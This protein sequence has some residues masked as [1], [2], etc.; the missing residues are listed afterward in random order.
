[1]CRKTKAWLIAAAALVLSGLLI[2][3]GVMMALDWDFSKLSTAE[4]ETNEYTITESFQNISLRSQTCNVVLIPSEEARVVCYEQS[5]MKHSVSVEGDT[6]V[7]AMDD[8]RKWYDHLGIHMEYP[9]ITVY[10]PQKQYGSITAAAT[11]G[12]I[13]LSGLSAGVLDLSVTTGDITAKDIHCAGDLRL[14]TTTGD[15]GLSTVSCKNLTAKGRTGDIGLEDV[16]TVEK[17]D[18]QLTTGDV[19]M[20]RCDATELKIKTTTG[21]ITG[22]LRSPKIITAKTATGSIR[23]PDSQTG[24]MCKLS[25]TT[26]D[27]TITLE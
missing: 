25:T 10:L 21:D 3:G 4:Y 16:I 6:L 19:K 1:M 27:I 23:I 13:T 18:I 9:K 2:F 26:G 11:T 22:S 14:H 5:K 12:D 7:I 15:I 20:D 17:F 8:Q 24:G